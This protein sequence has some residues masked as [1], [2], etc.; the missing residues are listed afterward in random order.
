[1]ISND[2]STNVRRAAHGDV[3]RLVQLNR[4]A[5]PDLIQDNVVFNERQLEAHLERFPTGQLVAETSGELVGAIST[6]IPDRRIDALAPHTWEGITDGG[7]FTRHDDGGSTLYLADIY[8]APAFQG[9]RVGQALYGALRD[10]CKSLRLAHVVAGG[11]L[12]G[13]SD[14][15]DRMTAQEYVQRVITGELRDRVLS[16]Q[17]RAGFVVRGLLSGYLHDWRSRHYATLLEWQNPDLTTADRRA[18][19]PKLSPSSEA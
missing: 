1:M 14:V 11:R 17:L 16:S 4:E 12:W 6:L 2:Q 13:Y 18:L 8:V 7:Y 9:R 3:T 10:L 15:A 5:Y 19:A